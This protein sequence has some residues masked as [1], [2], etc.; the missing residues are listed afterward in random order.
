[1]EAQRAQQERRGHLPHR[2]LVVDRE[3]G[4]DRRG[5]DRGGD[6]DLA[7]VRTL[8]DEIGEAEQRQRSHD[9]LPDD[10]DDDRRAQRDALR[11]EHDPGGE[12]THPAAGRSEQGERVVEGRSDVDAAQD[13]DQ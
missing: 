9:V 7:G 8:A 2:D 1:M 10:A 12:E 3:R 11:L 13:D 6:G 4:D 5:Q